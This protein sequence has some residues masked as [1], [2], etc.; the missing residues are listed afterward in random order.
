MS[1]VRYWIWFTQAIGYCTSRAKSLT[2][3]YDSIEDFYFGGEKEWRLC[4]LFSNNEI[5]KLTSTPLSVS[6]EILS[7]C[8]KYC[9]EVI[10]IDD[11][12]YPECLRAIDNP[13][14]VIYVWGMLPDIDNRLSIGVV[15]TRRASNY[16][17]SSSY[18]FAYKLASVGVTIV[19]GGALGVDCASHHGALA[20]DGVTICVLGCG[21]NYDYLRENA[22]M[23]SDI[24][25]KGAV[26]SEYPPDTEPRAYN[27][28]QRNRIISALS[29]GILLIEAG[30]KS[31]SLIT[32]E[33]A[34]EQDYKKKIFALAGTN[35]PRFDGSNELI[36]DNVAKLVTDYKDIID[37][38]DNLYATTELEPHNMPFD[39]VI[40][41]IPVKGKIPDS[42]NNFSTKQLEEVA[43]HKHNIKLN[44]NQSAVYYAVTADPIHIDR[45]AEITRIPVQKI[46]P[47]LTML[48]ISGL[49]KS[50]QGRCYKLK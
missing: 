27:F 36:K 3:L 47:I 12:T 35:D 43:V 45:I 37:A 32:V 34:L 46:L 23:R 29:D 30:K 1:N 7:R 24:T 26:I 50:V 11:V 13:P 17:K 9:Y 21:I 25:F 28:P 48:E 5:E 39:E 31:G 10:C 33:C 16:G 19:S 6:D 4:G 49:I 15:G 20:A 42:I 2:C 22:K 38:F 18:N 44:K 41:I 8:A 40:D 14:A